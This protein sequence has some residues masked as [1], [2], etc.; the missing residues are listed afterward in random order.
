MKKPRRVPRVRVVNSDPQPARLFMPHTFAN[1]VEFIG[2]GSPMVYMTRDAFSRM[3]HIVD[4][5]DDEVG[6][7]GTVRQTQYGNFLIE[8]VFL[9]EQEVS[10][11]Q[12]EISGD[13]IA[14]F[15][16]ELI[17]TREDG[18]EVANTIRFWGHS[19]VRMSTS[20]SGQDD[21]QMRHFEQNDCPWFVR[22]ILNKQGRMQFDIF[23][24]D[25]GVKITDAPWAI[26]D[27]FVD[28]SRRAEI[29]ADFKAKVTARTYTAHHYPGVPGEYSPLWAQGNPHL[30]GNM[31]GMMAASGAID[32]AGDDDVG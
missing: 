5:A 27:E 28:Q 17:E 12:T 24:W 16:Q 13:G 9:L 20:P 23:L 21:A 3:W 29:E 14:K 11:A 2:G 1:Q 22:G 8:E 7:L 19:H 25:A 18:V 15:V 26:F 30:F 31:A 4:I 6:W 32:G 10:A